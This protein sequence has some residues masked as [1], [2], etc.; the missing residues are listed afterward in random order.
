M[1]NIIDTNAINKLTYG[2]FVLTTK[3]AEKFNG[4]IINTVSQVTTTP[5][6]VTLAVNKGNYSHDLLMSTGVANVSILSERATFPLFTRFGFS[7]G[8]DTDKFAGFTAWETAE[9]G[10]PYIT[11]ATNAMLSLQVVSTM[12]LGTHT[13]FLADVT[14]AKL[15]FTDRS[16]TYQYYFDHIKPARKPEAAAPAA[17]TKKKW[18]CKIC[19][20]EHEGDELPADFICP[21]C[22]HPAEDFELVES[23]AAAPAAPAKKKWVCK[24]CGYEHEGDELPADFICP[25]C[26][27]PAEDFELA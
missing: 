2:L 16:V 1:T 24:I 17:T 23:P 20:Y 4:C 18:V 12:D 22:K 26:K 19:G 21:I 9:N 27:H 5:K 25:I 3:A 6:R 7:S 8:R 15:L 10:L 14:E 11:E 13:L